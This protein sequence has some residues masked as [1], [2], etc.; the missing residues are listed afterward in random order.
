MSLKLLTMDKGSLKFNGHCSNKRCSEFEVVK[1]NTYSICESCRMPMRKLKT[2]NEIAKEMETGLKET[3]V[4]VN[5]PAEIP[6]EVERLPEAQEKLYEID[7][8][9]FDIKKTIKDSVTDYVS[10][11]GE[12][13]YGALKDMVSE[14]V[15]VL[16][17]TVIKLEGRPDIKLEGRLHK[18]FEKCLFLCQQERQLFI[19]GPAGSG[20][21]TLAGQVAKALGL[22]FSHIS[23]SA[24]LS[25]AHLLGR[26]LFD[27]TYVSSDLV[28]CY[29]E[30]GVFLFD[31]IDAADANTL[32][33]INSALAN[34]VLSVPNRKDKNHA[35]RHKDFICICAGNTWGNGSF[36]YHGRNH[37]DAAFLDRFVMSKVMVEY[38]NELEREICGE[39]IELFNKLNEVRANVTKHKVRRVVSTRAYISGTRQMLAKRNLKK[40]MD[41]FFIGWSEEEVKK[42]THAN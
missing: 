2:L 20:K 18:E 12:V 17:P 25:E 15:K 7:M 4:Q 14:A 24:G 16:K 31:E 6:K 19:A 36:E 27:G 22:Q 29:E 9:G 28:R 5:V 26:M 32:L 10:G 3:S 8:E 40:V 35:V 38:D 33:T 30:G 42:A 11:Q 39:N 21:T 41:T 37:L 13:V 34:G 1:R 23:C